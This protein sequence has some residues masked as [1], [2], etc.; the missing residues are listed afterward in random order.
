MDIDGYVPPASFKPDMLA[1]EV[2][3][4]QYESRLQEPF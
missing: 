2:K 3:I 4:K 1:A